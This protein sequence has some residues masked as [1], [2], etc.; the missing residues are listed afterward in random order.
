MA[1]PIS[2]D[3]KRTANHPPPLAK[4]TRPRLYDAVRRPRL[5]ALLDDAAAR[6]IVWL[7]GA[8]GVGKTTLVASYLEARRLRHLWYHCD[9][10]DVDSA[11]FVHY[12]R[13][14]ATP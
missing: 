8:P 11:T 4:L 9:V 13:L 1:T 12:L 6:P 2:R 7:S 10:G 5:F 3:A 14:A